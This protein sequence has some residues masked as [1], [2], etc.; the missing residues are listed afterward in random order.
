VR[1]VIDT[2][3]LIAALIR[4]RGESASIV[5]AWREGRLEVAASEATVREAEM[6]LG[7]G[8]LGRMTSPERVR[9][10]LTALREESARVEDPP[11]VTDLP[12]KDAGDLRLVEAALAGG[13]EYIVTTDREFLSQRGYG[14]LEFVTPEEFLARAGL[15]QPQMDE[16]EHG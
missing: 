12:L 4:P 16:D 13:A 14:P 1:I 6:V 11:P 10:L 7:G 5:A 2:N 3:L 8:W 9:E 15:G